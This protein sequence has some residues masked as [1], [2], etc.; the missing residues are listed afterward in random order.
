MA[1]VSGNTMIN[2]AWKNGY[3]IGAFTAHN[4]ETIKAVLLAAQ[5]EQSPIMIQIGQKAINEM[6][7]MP[8]RTAIDSLIEHH[9]IT[10]PVC[11]HLDHSRKFEQCMEAAI[12]DF[13]SLMFDGSALEFEENVRITKAVVDV[14]N[15][16]GLGAEG[17]IGKIGGTEDDITVDEKDAMITTV[18]EA[19]DFSERTGVHYL[20]VSIGTAHGVYKT[21]PQLKFDRLSEIKEAVQ[22]P[23]VLHGGSG[24]PDEQVIEAVK[25]GVAKINV[26]TEL[27]QGFIDGVQ[28][29][30]QA[31][32]KDYVL[33]DV[34]N[35]GIASMKEVVR[36]KIRLFGSN[37]KA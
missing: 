2:E 26:D 17:E 6:G 28:A 20:A 11:V 29:H 23:I 18:A 24:V 37:G 12:C 32:A 22:K 35:T 31:N 34:M 4:L 15:A 3:A 1:Y 8:L 27:R 30:W 21:T 9:Q 16:L 19:L 10:V 7:M 36:H 33:A 5:E 13:Q 25:R 14:A